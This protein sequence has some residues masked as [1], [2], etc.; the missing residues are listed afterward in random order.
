MAAYRRVYDSRQLQA[1]WKESGS[2][3]EPYALQSCIGYLY[4]FSCSTRGYVV[5][6]GIRVSC[7]SCSSLRDAAAAGIRVSNHNYSSLRNAIY[8]YSSRRDVD[9][10][11]I[12][13]SSSS[14]SS[15]GEFKAASI[16]GDV[17]K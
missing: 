6:T 17:Q 4:H 5:T 2:V 7:D 15:L 3:P 16:G 8:S 12:G 13:V 9:T 1:D 11:G 10:T 14:F